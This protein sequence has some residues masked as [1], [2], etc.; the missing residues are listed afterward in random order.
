MDGYG[1]M[2]SFDL[3]SRTKA[4]R[5]ADS[6]K[7]VKNAV[8]LGGVESLVSIPVWTSHYGLRKRD[9]DRSGVTPGL[10]RLSVGLENVDELIKDINQALKKAFRG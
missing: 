7:L 6:L 3:G 10:V 9:L 8:S 2:V 5:F 4:A 1:G